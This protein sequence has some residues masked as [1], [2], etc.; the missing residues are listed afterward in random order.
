[1]MYLP[2]VIRYV[3]CIAIRVV[4]FSNGGYNIRKIYAKESTYPKKVIEF[5][6][7]DL[8]RAVRKCQNLTFKVNFL[9]QKSSKSLSI[10]FSLKNANLVVAY[11][12]LI[13][14]FL[15]KIN[16]WIILLL[17]WCPIFDSSPFIQNSKFNDYWVCWFLCK[18]RSNFLPPDWKLHYHYHN[19]KKF[20][21]EGKQ[22]I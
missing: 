19:V 15:N 21:L 2:S 4:E 16:V 6:V 5:W 12:F 22:R 20:S 17:K 9:C 14:F 10:F 18:N 1:M 3:N 8:W 7:L 13:E 11:L